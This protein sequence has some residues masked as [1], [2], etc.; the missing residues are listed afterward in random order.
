MLQRFMDI[1]GIPFA[2]AVRNDRNDS[3]HQAFVPLHQSSGYPVTHE[4]YH[5]HLFNQAWMPWFASRRVGRLA[6]QQCYETKLERHL[7]VALSVK[8]SWC[9]SSNLF[10]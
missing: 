7:G 4:G 1:A 6:Y 8:Q 2:Q 10:G 3:A 5:K 9:A